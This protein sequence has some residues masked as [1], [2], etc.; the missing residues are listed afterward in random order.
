MM[1]FVD[2]RWYQIW[3][4][5]VKIKSKTEILLGYV[6]KFRI[7]LFHL[8]SQNIWA[9]KGLTFN[10]RISDFGFMFLR[11][12]FIFKYTYR[13]SRTTSEEML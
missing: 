10:W 4:V 11:Q 1:N 2:T 9:F 8:N 3:N 7:A 13:L 12:G 6:N 5:M